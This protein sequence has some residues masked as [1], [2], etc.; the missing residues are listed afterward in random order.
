MFWLCR[1]LQMARQLNTGVPPEMVPDRHDKIKAVLTS[2]CLL[3]QAL[4]AASSREEAAFPREFFSIRLWWLKTCDVADFEMKVNMTFAWSLWSHVI[5]SS[6][7]CLAL[8]VTHSTS[9]SP[10]SQNTSWSIFSLEQNSF[11]AYVVSRED[12]KYLKLLN[13]FL[14]P[15]KWHCM[16]KAKEKYQVCYE[17]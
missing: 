6:F 11:Y 13:T 12:T 14:F 3:Q 9:L 4:P 15:G 8:L 5:N 7:P 16:W 10:M 1:W 17:F 2:P